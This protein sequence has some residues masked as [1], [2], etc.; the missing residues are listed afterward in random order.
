MGTPGYIWVLPHFFVDRYNRIVDPEVVVQICDWGAGVWCLQRL[1]HL[2]LPEFEGFNGRLRRF[3]VTGWLHAVLLRRY[4]DESES[5]E[6]S[7]SEVCVMAAVGRGVGIGFAPA[8]GVFM[9]VQRGAERTKYVSLR[10]RGRNI[11]D[12]SHDQ[13]RRRTEELA[14]DRAFVLENPLH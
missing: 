7:Q 11:V 13:P 14:V 1:I 9:L 4:P 6:E 2:A 3:L 8:A 10:H 12:G 5:K